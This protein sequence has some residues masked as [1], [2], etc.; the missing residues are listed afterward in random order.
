VSPN[1][2]DHHLS[3]LVDIVRAGGSVAEDDLD[4][5]VLRPLKTECLVLNRNGSVVTTPAGRAAARSFMEGGLD[6]RP[7]Q[8]MATPTEISRLSEPQ[9]DALRELCR[10]GRPVLAEAFDG[11]VLRALKVRGFAEESDGWVTATA[12][13]REHFDRHVRRR[14]R[15]QADPDFGVRNGRAEV[16]QRHIEGLELTIPAHTE[17]MVG[18]MP[19]SVDDVLAGLRRYARMLERSAP[20]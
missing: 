3:L 16:I 8:T 17:V 2:K 19:A 6:H 18:D 13:G 4:G 20:R 11:R 12:A 15:G 1:I 7:H 14:R 9:E 10:Q 5:R